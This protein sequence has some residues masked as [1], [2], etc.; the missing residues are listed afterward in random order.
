MK[1]SLLTQTS[2]TLVKKYQSWSSPTGV[3]DVR[4]LKELPPQPKGLPAASRTMVLIQTHTPLQAMTEKKKTAAATSTSPL[5]VLQSG[6]K[7]KRS[8]GNNGP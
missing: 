8:S 7:L 1:L 2:T 5:A 4:W 3:G 6:E